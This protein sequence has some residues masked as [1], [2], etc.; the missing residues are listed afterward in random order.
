MQPDVLHSQPE[1]LKQPVNQF[2]FRIDQGFAGDA[3]VEDRHTQQR[4]AVHDRHGHL[5][6]Q[7]LEL[8]ASLGVVA[9]FLALQFQNPAEPDELAANAGFEREFKMLE[10]TAGE[11]QGANRPQT[12]A[13]L[14]CLLGE[15]RRGRAH[16][17]DRAVDAHDLAKHQQKLPQHRLGIEGMGED[18]RKITQQAERLR[19]RY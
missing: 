3:R 9:R 8:L 19:R 15:G 4:L 7:Q 17:D 6:A 12:P 14:A 18:A 10:Q 1:L 16:E 5:A 11:S 13:F 2:Q